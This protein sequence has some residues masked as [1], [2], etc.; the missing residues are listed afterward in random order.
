ML[1]KIPKRNKKERG[2]EERGK[3]EGEWKRERKIFKIFKIGRERGRKRRER[4]KE[5]RKKRIT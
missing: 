1:R 3:R 2:G 4:E 5:K